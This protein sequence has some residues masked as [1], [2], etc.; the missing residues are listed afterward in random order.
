LNPDPD[1]TFQVNPDP[2]PIRIQRFDDQKLKEKKYR[3]KNSLIKNCNYLCPL[4]KL[5]EKTSALKRE[6]P[7]LNKKRTLL[8]IFMSVGNF[9]SS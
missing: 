1:P 7:A 8:T 4:S 9:C 5:Q 6:H 3:L 2:D